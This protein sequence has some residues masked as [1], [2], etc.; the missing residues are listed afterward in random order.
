MSFDINKPSSRV[1]VDIKLQ[2]KALV[3]NK[4]IHKLMSVH[5]S[6]KSLQT[7]TNFPC[8]KFLIELLIYENFCSWFF[9]SS[10]IVGKTHPSL[11]GLC[12]KIQ[13]SFI[14]GCSCCLKLRNYGT[15]SQGEAKKGWCRWVDGQA[16]SPDLHVVCG[17]GGKCSRACRRGY[18]QGETVDPA[19]FGQNPIQLI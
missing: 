12:S 5:V 16:H 10:Y 13:C 4:P 15:C 14:L 7:S 3:L 2:A 11:N 18:V 19:Y 17:K 1:I 9:L 6:A 8:T